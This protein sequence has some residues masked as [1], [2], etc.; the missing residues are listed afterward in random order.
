MSEAMA[1]L[2]SS[3]DVAAPKAGEPMKVERYADIL[4][5]T[6]HYP[7]SARAEVLARLEVPEGAWEDTQARWTDAL[8]AEAGQEERPVSRAFA[9]AFAAA[10]RRLKK[11]SPPLES[12]GQLA[13]KEPMPSAE[14]APGTPD[15]AGAAPP[16]LAARSTPALP[17][18]EPAPATPAAI[19]PPALVDAPP[20]EP[21]RA[22]PSALKGTALAFDVPYAHVLPFDPSAA[23]TLPATSALAAPRGPRV[24]KGTQLALDNEAG[25]VLPFSSAA[26]ATGAVGQEGAAR[27]APAA[28]DDTPL[29]PKP[30]G[31]ETADISSVLRN[32]LPFGPSAPPAA[33][34]VAPAEAPQL[35]LA[36]HAS[37]CVE[38][39]LDPAS[40]PEI[41]GRYRV[42]EE[43]K[44]ALDA[45]WQARLA[46]D[47]TLRAAWHQ[48][49]Q[50]Y[51]TWLL[52]QRGQHP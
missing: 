27:P 47:A 25:P 17:P 18:E 37:L 44:R 11:T 38:L 26:P 24:G 33:R 45:H 23:P 34:P 42:S 51:Q 50:S 7:P 4:A 46:A 20:A 22:V 35:S 28:L 21:R 8:I 19:A 2:K 49:Y 12:I 9:A 15:A 52:R 14:A 30:V 1:A 29:R 5:H 31:S 16:E 48:A 43:Q 39:A 40:S 3:E 6:L 32:P 36:Q 41:L 10:R 13:S